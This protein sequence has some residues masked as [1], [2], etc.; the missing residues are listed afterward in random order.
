[1]AQRLIE[2]LRR[3]R[4]GRDGERV[5]L[6]RVV[7]RRVDR[8]QGL[9]QVVDEDAGLQRRGGEAAVDV[10]GAFALDIDRG[11]AEHG[12]DEGRPA[13]EVD[14]APA[15]RVHGKVSAA[16]SLWRRALSSSR[17][18]PWTAATNWSTRACQRGW[19]GSTA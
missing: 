17:P 2:R 19:P 18:S 15:H 8:V 14:P 4:G 11:A 12:Q 16:S 9:G 10:L 6:G 3:G 5:H 1:M 13:G 7:Q